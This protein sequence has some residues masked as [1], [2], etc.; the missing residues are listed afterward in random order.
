M[1]GD[2]ERRAWHTRSPAF[3][4]NIGVSPRRETRPSRIPNKTIRGFV[5]E[6]SAK[7]TGH[8][9]V[10]QRTHDLFRSLEQCNRN[11]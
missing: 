8:A 2:A 4:R 1:R 9:R 11:I 6:S 7:G 3:D 5:R 10:A